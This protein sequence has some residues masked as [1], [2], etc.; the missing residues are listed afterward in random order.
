MA[1][2]GKIL[3]GTV[4]WF[5]DQRCYGF[6][7][8]DEGKTDIFFHFTYIQMEGF[9]TLKKGARVTF[10]LGKNHVGDM[11]INIQRIGEVEP[12]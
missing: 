11:A 8:P 1:S 4:V 3:H 12:E 2:T 7:K 10:E 6:I 9:K 5:S